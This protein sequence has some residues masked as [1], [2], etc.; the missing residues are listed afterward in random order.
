[1]SYQCYCICVASDSD[2]VRAHDETDL[3]KERTIVNCVMKSDPQHPPSSPRAR[4]R[5]RGAIA[6]FSRRR[7]TAAIT[8][9][10]TPSEASSASVSEGTPDSLPLA[11]VRGTA[12]TSSPPSSPSRG[13]K[14]RK[15]PPTLLPRVDA[16]RVTPCRLQTGVPSRPWTAFACH[17]APTARVLVFP[18]SSPL[19]LARRELT[20]GCHAPTHPATV[21]SSHQTLV[22]HTTGKS[23]VAVSPLDARDLGG[24]W[25]EKI[26]A[27]LVARAALN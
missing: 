9:E 5:L 20:V 16:G 12:L 26:V 11:L 23:A 21:I 13:H 8:N 3:R 4:A 22:A 6:R 17:G 1:M 14:E 10:R 2:S 27:S 24:W 25:L 7:R 15:Q 19:S 18:A